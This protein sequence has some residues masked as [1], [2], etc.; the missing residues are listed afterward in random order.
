MI[1]VRSAWLAAL[2]FAVLVSAAPVAAQPYKVRAFVQ[3]DSGITD[4]TPVQ[5]VIE[6]K[7]G[8]QNPDLL[9]PR[10]GKLVNLEVIG[11]PSTSSSFSWIN[12]KSTSSVQLRYALLPGGP[13]AAAIPAL[14]IKIDGKD[15]PIGGI[16]FNVVEGSTIAP[17]G[18]RRTQGRDGRRGVAE[19]DLFLRAE[20]ESADAWVG[21]PIGLTVTLYAR[22]NVN[23]PRWISQPA[24]SNFWVESIETDPDR[25][26]FRTRI[27]DT[28]YVAFPLARKV[29]IAP[30]PGNFEIEPYVL[31]LRV[32]SDWFDIF[33]RSQTVIRKSE[34]VNLHVRQ[35]P[36]EVPAGFSGAV[37][38]YSLEVVLDRTES[39]VNDAV[40]LR[41]T[42]RGE[43][44]LR[45]VAPPDWVVP[46]EI[47]VYD[48]EVTSAALPKG[49]KLMSEKTW[50]W[51]LI[52]LTPGDIE[53][54]AIRFPYFDPAKGSYQVAESPSMQLAVNQGDGAL[55][56]AP[57]ARGR[58][59]LLERQDLAFVKPLRGDRLAEARPRLHQRGLFIALIAAPLL[60]MPLLVLVGR[61]RDRLQRDHGLARSR[62]AR[63]RARRRF[64]AARR[65]LSDDD[66]AGFHEAVARSLVEYVADRFNRAPAG[67]TYELA[68]D[69]L[70][71]RGIDDDLRRRFR[72]CVEACDFARFVPASAQTE[73]RAE[74]LDEAMAVVD[75]VE[76]A[77]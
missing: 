3:P 42:V 55:S 6:V 50:E 44:S 48:P 62:R 63:G 70:A 74:L 9:P 56:D 16:R 36:E 66:S 18:G 5:F 52:P 65:R 34:A 11:G 73:R 31:Q 57:V 10:L 68:E 25:E 54:P 29:L 75:A 22:A 12:G 21:Q 43:G 38:D 61:H 41:A 15:Y 40:S 69:L 27:N 14:K 76:R 59:I 39:A 35:L 8:R 77:W 20:V 19:Q 1:G 24:F 32:G 45:S 60:W 28:E 17:R 53:L 67:L 46:P 4:T 37:G 2:G 71:S 47:K 58:G 26:S 13:G 49:G 30:G 51:I 64:R 23:D 72:A 33:G 7:G